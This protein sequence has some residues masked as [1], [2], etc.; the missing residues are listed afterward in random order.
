[1]NRLKDAH[2]IQRLPT[3]THIGVFLET[4]SGEYLLPKQEALAV[5]LPTLLASFQ[6][7]RGLM[8][9]VPVPRQL[10]SV[11]CRR[12]SHC[13]SSCCLRTDRHLCGTGSSSAALVPHG[14]CHPSHLH[15][16]PGLISGPASMTPGDE[17][18]LDCCQPSRLLSWPQPSR[19]PDQ[20][21][22]HTCDRWLS[23]HLRQGAPL[24]WLQSLD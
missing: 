9:Q 17:T 19:L 4:Y 24:G 7:T 14:L 11:W 15:F 13:S 21:Q 18:G 8:Q 10:N 20:L 22:G 2:N 3:T 12:S 6:T 1:M 16:N 23:A 5:A